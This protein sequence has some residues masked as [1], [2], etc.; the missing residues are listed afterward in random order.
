MPHFE[1]PQ[2]ETIICYKWYQCLAVFVFSDSLDSTGPVPSLANAVTLLHPE[3]MLSLPGFILA[4]TGN[5]KLAYVSENVSHFL[6]FSV[7]ELLAHGDSIFDLLSSSASKVMQEKLCFAQQH[8]GT[9]IEFITEMCTSK[10]FRIKYG[11]NRSMVMRGRFLMSDTQLILS[12]PALTFVAFCTPVAHVSEDEGSTFQ[13]SFQSKHTL[14]MKIAELTKNVVYHLGYQK[15]EMIGQ[16]WYS[17][18]HPEDIGRAAEMHRALMQSPGKNIWSVIVRLL[19]KD[20][21]WAWVQVA[22][23]RENGKAGELITCTNCILREEE[24]TYIQSQDLQ[25]GIVSQATSNKRYCYGEIQ[26]QTKVNDVNLSPQETARTRDEILRFNPSQLPEASEEKTATASFQPS[27]PTNLPSMADIANLHSSQETRFPFFPA[28]LS[29]TDQ[30]NRRDSL[31]PTALCSLESS[32]SSD[33]SS[34][35]DFSSPAEGRSSSGTYSVMGT[36]LDQD[37]WAIS[38][39]AKQIHCLDEIFS[40][41]TKE[42]PQ[43]P[44][45]IPLWLGQPA[46]V[47]RQSWGTDGALDFLE[48]FS[49]DEEVISSI[50]NN[51]LHHDSLNQSNSESS[52]TGNF[53]ISNTESELP[54]LPASLIEATSC[55]DQCPFMQPFSSSASSGSHVP[56]SHWD[57]T[58]NAMLEQGAVSSSL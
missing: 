45:D 8:P 15:E 46:M 26:Q 25:Y 13:N 2:K 31:S 5:G 57:G 37:K 36:S 42:I 11:K 34:T 55:L 20:L 19:C 22:A 35:I 33:S 24:A 49:L 27:F 7:V 54:L 44:P 23:S 21:N 43:Q 4:F 50:L 30:R 9:A 3:L 56:D 38:I 16:S 28:G 39:L 17:L 1:D 14:D 32:F 47:S 6:G 58:I 41:Y 52:P 18:L 48:E 40:Q 53:H 12:S 10:A 29:S 51:L